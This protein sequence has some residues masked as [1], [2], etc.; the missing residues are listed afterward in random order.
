MCFPSFYTMLYPS[1]TI[2]YSTYRYQTFSVRIYKFKIINLRYFCFC[3]VLTRM[4]P[5]P[6]FTKVNIL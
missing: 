4:L 1:I 2:L 6:P 5:P 3:R